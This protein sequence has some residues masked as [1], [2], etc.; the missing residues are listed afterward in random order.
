MSSSVSLMVAAHKDYEFPEDKGY[1]PVQVGRSLAANK[2]NITGDD[3]GDNI[4]HL[5]KSFCELTGLYWLWKNQASDFYG[6]AHYR[7]YFKP[8]SGDGVRVAGKAIAATEDLLK[9]LDGYSILLS[10]P[11][12]YWIESVRK[13]YVNAH[14]ASDLDALRQ[15][16]SEKHP[17]YVASFDTVMGR[18]RVSL[19]NMFFM[20]ADLFNSYCSWLF[21]ILFELEKRIPYKSYGAYQGRVFGFLAE[22][23]LNVWVEKNI[24]PA[25]IKYLPVINIEGEN[26]F[27]KAIGLLERKFKGVKQE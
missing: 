16:L 10:K 19:Y 22:R 1:L 20:R 21:S 3:S 13:H 15:V 27:K 7:R 5:N 9:Q 4:S 8:V 25:Q 2:L 12:N 11:R 18:T 26:L 6:L 17:E 24:D 14:N 23:L